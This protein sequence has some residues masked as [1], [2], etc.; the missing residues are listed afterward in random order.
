MQ[1]FSYWADLR[2]PKSTEAD[3]RQNGNAGTFYEAFLRG[4]PQLTVMVERYQ[5]SRRIFM[6]R[7]RACGHS[8][9]GLEDHV[10]EGY[11]TSRLSW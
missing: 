8:V 1:Y 2:D 9:Q 5:L 3:S 11:F 10:E 6:T 7:E 4:K